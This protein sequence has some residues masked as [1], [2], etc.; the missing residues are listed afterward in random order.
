M[1]GY[2]FIMPL[3]AIHSFFHFFLILFSCFN[4]DPC[5]NFVLLFS[6]IPLD[7]SASRKKFQ[8]TCSEKY[9]WQ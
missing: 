9:K 2:D 3:T 4:Y 1:C 8:C 5:S 6:V 7:L